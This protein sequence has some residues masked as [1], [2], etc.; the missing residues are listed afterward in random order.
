[1]TTFK[2]VQEKRRRRQ[3]R[4]RKTINGTAARPR[5]CVSV[6]ANNIYVQ[7][8]DDVNGVTLAS[9]S[10]LD[11]QFKEAKVKTNVAGAQVLGKLAAERAQAAN[12]TTVVFDRAGRSF[13]G[14]VKAI[15]EAAREVGLKF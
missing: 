3:L 5:M 14:K 15:A 10:S 7:F 6:T 13:H 8:I 4:I 12:V 11:K 9:C 1:M 2:T